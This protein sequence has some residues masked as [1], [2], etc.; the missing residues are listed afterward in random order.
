MLLELLGTGGM[1]LL[2]LVETGALLVAVLVHTTHSRPWGHPTAPSSLR[3]LWGNRA[4]RVWEGR[5]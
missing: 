2:E 1:K 5:E 4:F 3:S